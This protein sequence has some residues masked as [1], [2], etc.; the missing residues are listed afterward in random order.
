MKKF[1]AILVLLAA[2]FALNGCATYK[3][4]LVDGTDNSSMTL[5]LGAVFGKVNPG[6]ANGSY[7]WDGDG[8]GQ[9]TVGAN[10]EGADTTGAIELIKLLMPLL[11]SI[12]Q[13][14]VGPQPVA[15]VAA[16]PDVASLSAQLESMR[17]IINT[18]RERR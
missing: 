5:E 4:K 15:P 10:S 9:W 12:P 2:V 14:T 16:A 11:Q 8:S 1:V 7:L 6:D 13:L 18:L 3:A 17:A